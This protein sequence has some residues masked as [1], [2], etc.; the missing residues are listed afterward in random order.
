MMKLIGPLAALFLASCATTPAEIRSRDVVFTG[1]TQRPPMEVANCLSD[2][3]SNL[4]S[5]RVSERTDGTLVEINHDGS[6]VISFQIDG[7]GNVTGRRANS[8]L[9]IEKKA[10]GCLA[11]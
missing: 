10:T 4:G 5:P 7:S 6:T 11:G 3:F 1:H 8:L 9:P 2:S